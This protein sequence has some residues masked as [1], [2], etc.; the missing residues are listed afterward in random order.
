MVHLW[1]R[2]CSIQRRHQKVIEEAPAPRLDQASRDAMGAQAVA[3]ALAARY[4]SAGTVEFVVD[5]DG[6]F[7]FLEMN[8]RIQ[9]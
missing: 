5:K 8:T 4:H 6:A 9:V 7:Y 2:D 1:E 3:L